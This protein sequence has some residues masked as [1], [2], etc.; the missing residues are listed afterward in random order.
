MLQHQRPAAIY[1]TGFIQ[2]L[3][4][5][6]HLRQTLRAIP[7]CSILASSQWPKNARPTAGRVH[8]YGKRTDESLLNIVQLKLFRSPLRQKLGA[9]AKFMTGIAGRLHVYSIYFT[10]LGWF[11]ARLRSLSTATVSS[12]PGCAVVG[13]LAYRE[14]R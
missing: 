1:Y 3:D 11:G 2:L 5:E 6:S 4:P 14:G 12:R 13:P 7:K 8:G 10:F 9:A